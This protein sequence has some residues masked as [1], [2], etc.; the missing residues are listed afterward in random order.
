MSFPLEALGNYVILKINPKSK[1]KGQIHLPDSA[2]EGNEDFAE[3]VS[4]GPL[5]VGNLEA[6]DMVLCPEVGD[7]EWTD[8]DDN[9]QKYFIL[10][11]TAIP[12]KVTG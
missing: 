7:F 10:E 3:V 1:M 11:E 6:G 5:C 2:S 12:A 9:D 8:E 4:V